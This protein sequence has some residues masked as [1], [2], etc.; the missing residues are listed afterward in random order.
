MPLKYGKD[1]RKGRISIVGHVY[2]TT[3]VTKGREPVFAD[4]DPARRVVDCL[5]ASD[6]SE[7]TDTLAFVLMPDHL[8]WL[9][10][11]KNADLA[12]VMNRFKGR[13]SRILTALG[14]ASAPV[15]QRGY[16]DHAVRSH[17]NLKAIARYIVAN[18][19]RAR[20]VRHIGDYPWWDAVWL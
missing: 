11:L 18:P 17:E 2:H 3:T 5:K 1:L 7:L 4:F 12:V 16:H 19:L 8:H 13:S 20:L 9:F 14:A 15:W 6:A 10:Q